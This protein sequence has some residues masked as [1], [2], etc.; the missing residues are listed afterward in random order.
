MGETP[1]V[2]LSRP[3]TRAAVVA[4]AAVVAVAVAAGIAAVVT[5]DSTG[6]GANTFPV[7][8]RYDD[9]QYAKT[10]PALVIYDEAA[11]IGTGFAEPRGVAAHHD[12]R[13]LVAGDGAVRVFSKEGERLADWSVAGE[14]R[15]LAVSRAGLMYVVM[16][17]HVVVLGEDGSAAASWPPFGGRAYL[18]SVAVSE[19]GQ[20]VFVADAG[21]KVVYRCDP[22]GA[23]VAR[24]GERAPDRHVPGLVVYQPCLDVCVGRDGFLRVVSPGM[25]RVE[26]YG[27]TGD[28][29]A[30]W[31]RV[32]PTMDAFSGCCN[33]VNVAL[34]PDDAMV[35][36]EKHLPRVKVSDGAGRLVGVVVG[37]EGFEGR[38][39]GIDVA[40]DPDWR[41]LVLDPSSRSV[42]VF[43]RK[44]GRGG[45]GSRPAD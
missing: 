9:S 41:V 6:G 14:P 43:V 29:V 40:V 38:P 44:A 31:G 36:A 32:G 4:A 19:D 15:T 5:L 1:S 30:Q 25:H 27:F 26:S 18:T 12:G 37:V 22:S 42:R 13:I 35:T 17:E 28:L 10:D 34:F 16:P 3:R 20:D 23:V 8:S 2:P 21:N 7:E 45:P 24:I 33:P 11:R 39:K